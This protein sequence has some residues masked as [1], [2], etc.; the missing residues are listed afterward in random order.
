MDELNLNEY[1]VYDVF[2]ILHDLHQEI[3][4]WEARNRNKLYY[5]SVRIG[6]AC[7][8]PNET[9]MER[10]DVV[11]IGAGSG[12]SPYLPLLEEVIRQDKGKSSNYNFDTARLIFI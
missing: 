4:L 8:T 10:K 6:R 9:F 3:P 1:E 7:S 12:I 5:P 2:N 11:L